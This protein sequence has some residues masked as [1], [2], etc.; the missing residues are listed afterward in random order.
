[1]AR[2]QMGGAFRFE[3][4]GKPM[5]SD[6]TRQAD[7]DE[8]AIERIEMQKL[9]AYQQSGADYLEQMKSADRRADLQDRIVR[10]GQTRDRG[11]ARGPQR[12]RDRACRLSR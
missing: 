5:T 1:M 9:E 6:E 12:S 2:S 7:E 4:R 3:E 10:A 8:R 11:L